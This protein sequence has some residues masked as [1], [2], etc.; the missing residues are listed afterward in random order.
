MDDED[1][2]PEF[3]DPDPEFL[4]SFNWKSKIPSVSCTKTITM[5]I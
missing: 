5:P 3:Q 4:K 1:P 2:E